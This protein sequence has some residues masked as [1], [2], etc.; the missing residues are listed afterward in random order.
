M[1]KVFKRSTSKPWVLWLLSVLVVCDAMASG[2]EVEY[3]NAL[4]AAQKLEQHPEI[5]VLD[6]R[7]PEEFEKA[8]ING[9][10]N[11]DYF[12]PRFFDSLIQLNKNKK[13]LLY[14]RSGGRSRRALSIIEEAGL[15]NV[16]H[17]DG[18]IKGWIKQGLLVK[19]GSK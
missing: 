13:Y 6:I 7:T 3:V 4:Q 10:I 19:A 17:L 9:A 1:T 14:C 11:L 8:H 5:I 18:G 2:F 12:S 16:L 15:T